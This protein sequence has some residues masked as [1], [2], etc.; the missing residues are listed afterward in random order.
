LIPSL[1]NDDILSEYFTQ[2]D[3]EIEINIL[4]GDIIGHCERKVRMKMCLILNGC[5][6]RATKISRPNCVK[7]LFVG[8]DEE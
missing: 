5:R 7:L 3:S 6:N 2:G 1:F 8:L 4:E